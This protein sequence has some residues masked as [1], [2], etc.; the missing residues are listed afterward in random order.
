[1]NGNRNDDV[2]TDWFINSINDLSYSATKSLIKHYITS[3]PDFEYPSEL[4]DEVNNRRSYG[5]LLSEACKLIEDNLKEYAE[6]DGSNVK[7]AYYKDGTTESELFGRCYIR[8]TTA[9]RLMLRNNSYVRFNKVDLG[10]FINKPFKDIYMLKKLGKDLD[11]LI[12]NKE[13]FPNNNEISRFYNKVKDVR[14]NMILQSDIRCEI[15]TNTDSDDY[16]ATYYYKASVD[17]DDY[18]NEPDRNDSYTHTDGNDSVRFTYNDDENIAGGGNDTDP[19]KYYYEDLHIKK[20]DIRFNMFTLRLRVITDNF[21]IIRMPRIDNTQ[22]RLKD[23]IITIPVITPEAHL[24]DL[25]TTYM[26]KILNSD[27]KI[28]KTRLE[29]R[30]LSNSN[31][32]SLDGTSILLINYSSSNNNY[33]KSVEKNIEKVL[34]HLRSGKELYPYGALFSLIKSITTIGKEIESKLI[35]ESLKEEREVGKESLKYKEFMKSYITTLVNEIPS[36]EYI[37]DGISRARNT[38]EISNLKPNEI[39]KSKTIQ[40]FYGGDGFVSKRLIFNYKNMDDLKYDDVDIYLADLIEHIYI[41]KESDDLNL[42]LT[43]LINLG[44]N[45]KWSVECKKYLIGY[46]ITYPQYIKMYNFNQDKMKI[47]VSRSNMHQAF[48]K[49]LNNENKMN[50]NASKLNMVNEVGPTVTDK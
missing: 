5:I 39:L 17:D 8:D 11:Q 37:Q 47:K 30:E 4:L 27:R 12:T 1:M 29:A 19:N 35:E 43:N 50:T 15:V 6:V 20:S 16:F 24:N 49:L 33:Y 23:S 3:L 25:L 28:Y 2:F 34:K 18:N 41:N 7:N 32:L 22:I 45:H 31:I 26:R 14:E 38:K 10:I 42:Y 36:F 21:D 13:V 40:Q 9:S 44:E 48:K 46:E